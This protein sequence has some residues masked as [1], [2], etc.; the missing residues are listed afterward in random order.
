MRAH[1]V[2]H[3]AKGIL[4]MGERNIVTSSTTAVVGGQ[5]RARHLSKAFFTPHSASR[6]TDRSIMLMSSK[7]NILGLVKDSL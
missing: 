7:A 2:S 4:Y 6:L 5:E 3:G 1:V